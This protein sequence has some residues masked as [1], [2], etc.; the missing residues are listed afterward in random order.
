MHDVVIIGA[1]PAGLTAASY[2]GRFLRP[3]L[4][5]DGGASRARWIPESHNIPGFPQ[6]IV[7]LQLLASLREQA[8]KYGTSIQTGDVHAITAHD[9]YFELNLGNEQVS[10][11]Y[12]VLATGVKDHLP[13]L[14]G[15]DEALLRS[16]LRVCPICDG[17]ESAGKRIAVI[18]DSERAENEAQFLLT[19]SDRITLIDISALP[20]A[21]RRRRI[22]AR[23]IEYLQA[24]L[25]ELL[26]EENEL[27]LRQAD[28]KCR[29]F[30]Y[31][32]TALGCSPR[33]EL[34]AALGTHFDKNDALTVDA[35]QQTSVD[36]LYAAGDI[37]RG[38]SQ[39][40]VAAAEAAIAATAIHN[41]LRRAS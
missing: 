14:S 33:N 30:D 3:A 4:L 9:E 41:R 29:T 20:D 36:R 10:T 15:A 18:G 26:I 13:N 11:R 23:G 37:V 27:R 40:V 17:Y 1:G 12:I 6:G 38:L 32:Y 21:Y 2:L 8:I 5:I 34:A 22:E 39:V 28:G 16:L 7:G 24:S 31:F 25:K 19:Y 35:Q